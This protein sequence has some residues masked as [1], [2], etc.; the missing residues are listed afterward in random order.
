MAFAA[1]DAFWAVFAEAFAACAVFTEVSVVLIAALEVAC[2]VLIPFS[3]VLTVPLAVVFTAFS[4]FRA[5]LL[6]IFCPCCRVFI[7]CD[8]AVWETSGQRNGL[9][10]RDGSAS[11]VVLTYSVLLSVL[12]L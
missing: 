4:A 10:P 6:I 3:V 2:A 12:R 7:N 11:R 1:C 9:Q 5:V 8:F